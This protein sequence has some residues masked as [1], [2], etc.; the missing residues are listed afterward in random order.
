MLAG[1]P[2]EWIAALESLIDDAEL[3]QRIGCSG[4][5]SVE[6][7]YSMDRCAELFA[8][9]VYETVNGKPVYAVEATAEELQ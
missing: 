4:R 1:T 3:R 6:E 5:N 7:H 2:E 9:T 8:N